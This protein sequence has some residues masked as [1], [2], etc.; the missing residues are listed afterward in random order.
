MTTLLLCS[1]CAPAVQARVYGHDFWINLLLVVLPVLV[2]LL[3]GACLA[4]RQGA[5]D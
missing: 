3:I 5:P 1:R 2:M 4:V